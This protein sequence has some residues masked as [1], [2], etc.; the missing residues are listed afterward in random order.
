MAHKKKATKSKKMAVTTRS[1]DIPLHQDSEEDEEQEQQEEQEEPEQEQESNNDDDDDDD[2]NDSNVE[3]GAA[4][5]QASKRKS[6]K[7]T[8]PCGLGYTQEETETLLSCIHEVIPIGPQDWEN[9]LQKHYEKFPETDRDVTSIRRKYNKLHTARVPTGD[10]SCPPLVRQAKRIHRDIEEKMDAQEELNEEELGFPSSDA[11]DN[12]VVDSPAP[13]AAVAAT[14]VAAPTI[15]VP[16]AHN[17]PALFRR[18]KRAKIEPQGVSSKVDGLLSVLVTKMVQDQDRVE[19]LRCERQQQQCIENRRNDMMTMMST[20]MATMPS[21]L[22]RQMSQI[23]NGE[24]N[25]EEPNEPN[26][27]EANEE[28]EEADSSNTK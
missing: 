14:A 13:A 6:T 1:K 5:S 17:S 22:Q 25:E 8:K 9:V 2:A 19:E 16:E 11:E 21:H 3:E 10:P 24:T 18:G 20:M 15:P 12:V 28:E 7:R 26:E 27:Q 4:T 23:V